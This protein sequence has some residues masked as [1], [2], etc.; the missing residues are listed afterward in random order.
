[1]EHFYFLKMMQQSKCFI[2]QW[3]WLWV[4]LRVL[5]TAGVFH[6]LAKLSGEGRKKDGGEGGEGR[7]EGVGREGGEGSGGARCVEGKAR[8]IN[9]IAQSLQ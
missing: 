7:G 8:D 2:R 6:D 9:T 4:W 5:S 1:M 3:V